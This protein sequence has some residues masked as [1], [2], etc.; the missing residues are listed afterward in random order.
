[1]EHLQLTQGVA[2][3]KPDE[4]EGCSPVSGGKTIRLCSSWPAS[5]QVLPTFPFVPV[6]ITKM[7]WPIFTKKLIPPVLIGVCRLGSGPRGAPPLGC[8]HQQVTLYDIR[9][10]KTLLTQPRPA[11][12]TPLVFNH[13]N[14]ICGACRHGR[15]LGFF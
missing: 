5:T 2:S 6:G 8:Y 3:L 15:N 9:S 14:A 7:V 10:L 1:M 13:T 12:I 4:S 11:S